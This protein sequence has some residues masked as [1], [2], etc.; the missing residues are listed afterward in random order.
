MST[1][2]V[3]SRSLSFLA[4]L[5]VLVVGAGC[6]TDKAVRAQAT[7]YH[8]EL[9]PA[10]LTDPELRD[11]LQ[12][13]GDRV[14]ASAKELHAQK[15]GPKSAFKDDSSWMF[16]S[17]KFHL[18]N[19]STLNAFTTGGD[20]AYI[21]SQLMKECRNEDE[22]AAVVAHEY[23]HVYARHVHKGMDRQYGVIG[24][25]LLLGAAGYAAGGEKHGKE[26]ALYGA[27]L[28]MIA[29]NFL[30]MGFTRDD[31]AE[32]D[33]LGFEFYARAG[34]DPARFG[35]LFQ[36][37]IDKGLDKTPEALSDHPSLSS[38]V[39]VAKERAAALPANAKD[40]RKPP[41]ADEKRYAELKKRAEAVGKTAPNDQSLARAKLLLAAV[42]SCLAPT[43]TQ[44]QKDARATL[45]A[46]QAEEEGAKKGK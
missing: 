34:W 44:E 37:L 4:L 15:F 23:G 6:A 29:G 31:E 20:H 12:Q 8:K 25:A 5:L 1:A 2:L 41:I 3:R 40:W 26:Y 21:Y 24:G 32:A 43:E 42:K 28:G 19:S 30:A 46:A 10:V 9:E 33:K 14:V 18:V 35:G 11:Y 13:L 7:D 39:Q 27:G 38:R 16:T 36:T 22:L 45:E 17:E